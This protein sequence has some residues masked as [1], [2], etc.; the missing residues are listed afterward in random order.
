[1]GGVS[2]PAFF[3]S[4]LDNSV[5]NRL[6]IHGSVLAFFVQKPKAVR[7]STKTI[8]ILPNVRGKFS[9]GGGDMSTKSKLTLKYLFLLIKIFFR[10]HIHC[11]QFGKFRK[12]IKKVELMVA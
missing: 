11:Q 6:N 3:F 2:I 10:L 5:R 7:L 1:M 9:K 12:N 8:A 4:F